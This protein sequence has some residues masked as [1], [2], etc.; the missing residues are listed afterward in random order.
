M[1]KLNKMLSGVALGLISMGLVA[2]S[3]KDTTPQTLGPNKAELILFQDQETDIKPY[4]TRIIVTDDFMRSDDGT[5]DSDFVLFDRKTQTVYSVAHSEHTILVVHAKPV[6]TQSPIKLKLDARRIEH[7]NAP[8]IGG[9]SP[10]QYD[11]LVNGKVC[12]HVIAVPGLLPVALEALR[13]FRRT[14][15]GQHAENIPKTPVDMLNPCF[16]ADDVFNP[17]RELQ[18]GFPLR[19]WGEDG[20]KRALMDYKTDFHADPKLFVL[21][22]GYQREEIGKSGVTTDS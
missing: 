19:Q 18:Y 11:L 22:K 20:K 1:K 14:L 10:V 4:L 8:K 9:K 13:E 17:G 6:E 15:S 2:C 3:G 12:R 16:L 21:P 7:V 5:A